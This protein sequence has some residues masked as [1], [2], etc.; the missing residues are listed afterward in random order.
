MSLTKVKKIIYAAIIISS[1]IFSCSLA[2]GQERDPGADKPI[3][4]PREALAQTTDG[5]PE[6]PPTDPSDEPPPTFF[7]EE[8]ESLDG[9]LIYV[10]DV[11]CSMD[12]M[13][14]G[15]T[16]LERAQAELSR[17]ISNLPRSIQ[18]NV[19]SFSCATYI[20]WRQPALAPADSTYKA[21]ALSFVNKQFSHGGTGTNSG[22][23]QAL[24][25]G[26]STV[27]LLT[28]GEPSCGD[29]PDRH[30]QMIR[31][32]NTQGAAIHVFGIGASGKFEAWCR[33]VADENSGVY[34]SVR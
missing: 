7:G 15:K 6:N 34:V 26:A 21:I 25:S 27:V 13:M 31:W 9:T 2:V 24:S 29:T 14:E 10:I 22:C 17:S 4:H 30:R 5:P 28:D 23:M 32:A 1:F 11:S 18:F 3:L 12:T 16:R 8:L 33:A 19:V 20:A